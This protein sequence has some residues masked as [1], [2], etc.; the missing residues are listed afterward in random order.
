MCSHSSTVSVESLSIRSHCAPH[1]NHICGIFTTRVVVFIAD[2]THLGRHFT[3][4]RFSYNETYTLKCDAVHW[5]FW[6]FVSSREGH[7][8]TPRGA[9]HYIQSCRFRFSLVNLFL[10]EIVTGNDSGP[11]NMCTLPS[12]VP[13]IHNM[14]TRTTPHSKG[15]TLTP[16]HTAFRH[17]VWRTSS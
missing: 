3:K 8:H 13:Q 9:S 17:A 2:S 16:R 1:S 12:H 6:S 5:E 15:K 4:Q 10:Q 11:P 14:C 7:I